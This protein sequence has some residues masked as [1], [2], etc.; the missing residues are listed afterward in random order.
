[1]T[2]AA[3]APIIALFNSSSS[4]EPPDGRVV[5]ATNTS[6]ALCRGS[7][8]ASD[9]STVGRTIDFNNGEIPIAE[10]LAT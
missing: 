10:A 1:M 3:D 2:A 4:P 7:P 5:V 8:T 6:V 9:D